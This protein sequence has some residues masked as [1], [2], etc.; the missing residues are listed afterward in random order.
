M[1]G[2]KASLGRDKP[3]RHLFVSPPAGGSA[4]RQAGEGGY[5]QCVTKPRTGHPRD[6]RAIKKDRRSQEPKV[7]SRTSD[8]P[9]RPRLASS[10]SPLPPAG[11]ETEETSPLTRTRALPPAS[12]ERAPLGAKR[13]ARSWEAFVPITRIRA[14]CAV[15]SGKEHR[16][17]AIQIR[18][19][20]PT[21]TRVLADGRPVPGHGSEPTRSKPASIETPY[22]FPRSAWSRSMASKRALKLPS[23]KPTA[24]RRSMNS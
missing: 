20:T 16:R 21:A 15:G 6:A 17:E 23:P 3:G 10:P 4:G 1:V 2:T 9:H 13:A 24:P 5:E 7:M 11:E 8:N 19:A 18:G 14:T 22:R 12:P